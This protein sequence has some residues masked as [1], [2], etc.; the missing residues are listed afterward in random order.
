[1]DKGNH[2]NHVEI[3]HQPLYV[4]EVDHNI[5]EVGIMAIR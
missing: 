1:M 5:E 2:E 4:E 3:E